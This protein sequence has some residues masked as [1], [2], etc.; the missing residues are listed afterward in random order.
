[1]SK[2]AQANAVTGHT[3]CVGLAGNTLLALD[4]C[5]VS[6]P[7]AQLSRDTAERSLVM[8][9]EASHLGAAP[10]SREAT[11]YQ[12]AYHT[13]PID[14]EFPFPGLAYALQ[15]PSEIAM[16]NAYQL[17]GSN[18][19]NCAPGTGPSILFDMLAS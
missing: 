13:H 15:Q 11:I 5:P 6:S 3:A 10:P 7:A 19:P 4:Q 14:A 18:G 8:T 1:M 12:R 17:T 2:I 9:R 16:E